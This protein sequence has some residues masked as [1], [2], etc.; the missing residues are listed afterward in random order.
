MVKHCCEDM[1]NNIYVT[2]EHDILDDTK[3]DECKVIYFSARFREYG[4]PVKNCEKIASS[5]ITI[6][7]CPWCGKRLPSSKRDEW[8]D[9]LR[10]M[11][12]NSPLSQKIPSQFESDDWYS[13]KKRRFRKHK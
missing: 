4:I 13:K 12:Y 3:T 7:V 1:C 11:G 8:F 9:R 6:N 2:N 5:Y 10:K